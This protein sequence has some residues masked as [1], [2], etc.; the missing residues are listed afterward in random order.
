MATASFDTARRGDGAVS[1]A[2]PPAIEK[3]PEIR[4]EA[5]GTTGRTYEA[6]EADALRA[7]AR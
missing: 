2:Q 4:P 3:T 5:L 6:A 1:A 7:F